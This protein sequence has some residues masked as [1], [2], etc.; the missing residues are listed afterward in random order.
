MCVGVICSCMPSLSLL[1]NHPDSKRLW[2][3]LKSTNHSIR[4][5]TLTGRS[6]GKASKHEFPSGKRTYANIKENFSTGSSDPLDL[7]LEL[8]R[9]GQFNSFETHVG[10]DRHG[11]PP[12]DGLYRTTE[13]EQWSVER[14]QAPRREIVA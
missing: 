7:D 4:G 5:S 3:K 14:S 12:V 2:S 9:V 10:T 6:S 13:V 1:A 8:G 11:K